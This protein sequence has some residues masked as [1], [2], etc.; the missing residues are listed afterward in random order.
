MG[1]AV[2]SG[3]VTAYCIRE[4]ITRSPGVENCVNRTLFFVKKLETASNKMLE[5]C[6]PR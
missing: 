6:G 1:L 5:E 2:S 3:T 4:T